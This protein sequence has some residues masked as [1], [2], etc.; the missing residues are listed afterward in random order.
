MGMAKVIDEAELRVCGIDALNKA[1]GAA[2]ALRFL[3]LLHKEP[4][5]YVEVSRKLYEN[6]TIDE[7]Y[8]RALKNP[9]L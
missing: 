2:G 9:D 5:D 1:L 3:T 8:E 6:Q 4:T 7:I